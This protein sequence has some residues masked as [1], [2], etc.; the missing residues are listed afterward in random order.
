VRNAPIR[1]A[2]PEWDAR[3]VYFP[4]QYGPSVV[5]LP[6]F[7]QPSF[8][9]NLIPIYDDNWG[10][11]EGYRGRAVVV[12]EWGGGYEGLDMTWQNFFGSYMVSR[13]VTDN[14]YWSLNPDR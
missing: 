8:P 10:Y 12:G 11:V 6:E 7:Y 14:F 2:K 5:S 3:V 4:H 9:N 1:L 13:C